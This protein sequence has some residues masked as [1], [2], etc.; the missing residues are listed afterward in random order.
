M[1]SEVWGY[2]EADR[3]EVRL[4]S[5]SAAVSAKWHMTTVTSEDSQISG[6]WKVVPA[7]TEPHGITCE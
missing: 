1:P 5:K 2:K 6:N 4:L 3:V 7:K